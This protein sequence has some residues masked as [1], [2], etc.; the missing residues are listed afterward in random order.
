M[1]STLMLVLRV[2]MQRHDA[3]AEWMESLHSQSKL[4]MQ[5]GERTFSSTIRLLQ[6]NIFPLN[7][8]ITKFIF[9]NHSLTRELQGFLTLLNFF[10]VNF[11]PYFF[12]LLRIEYSFFQMRNVVNSKILNFLKVLLPI[13]ETLHKGCNFEF[14][15]IS[16]KTPLD[17]NE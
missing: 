15:L 1:T 6:K 16:Y 5:R 3:L 11:F 4:C 17:K 2:Q 9:K 7:F 13:A 12:Y 14:S 8:L 10:L